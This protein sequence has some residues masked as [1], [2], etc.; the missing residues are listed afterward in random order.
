[1]G[2]EGLLLASWSISFPY[3]I[4]EVIGDT[5]IPA[6]LEHTLR[7][8]RMAHLTKD[9]VWN[10]YNLRPEGIET[11]IIDK[12]FCD[13]YFDKM[14]TSDNYRLSLVMCDTPFANF[15][16]FLNP[17]LHPEKHTNVL[18]KVATTIIKAYLNM[19]KVDWSKLLMKV[20]TKQLKNPKSK[21]SSSRAGCA[22]T[23]FAMYIYHHIECLTAAKKKTYKEKEDEWNYGIMDEPP[24]EIE[25][26]K[27]KTTF[28]QGKWDP[29]RRWFRKSG[30]LGRW[31]RW[32][33]GS[34]KGFISWGS[35][36]RIRGGGQVTPCAIQRTTNRIGWHYGW[37]TTKKMGKSN[38]LWFRWWAQVSSQLW[39]WRALT[40]DFMIYGFK[41]N[42]S[43]IASML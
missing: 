7:G 29:S 6:G 30:L 3:I 18:V 1:M 4:S 31:S 24:T 10:T 12:K 11:Y 9:V 34:I 38:C 15:I 2:C 17:I 14:N 19:M 27:G 13:G 40:K 28:K 43:N 23:P 16:W 33:V 35:N 20:I 22:L 5:T 41:R 26:A 32:G 25:M 36:Q 42:I 8:L 39:S 37:R 21:S